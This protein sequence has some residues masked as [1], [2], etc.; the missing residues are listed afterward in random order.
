MKLG[1]PGITALIRKNAARL[2][3]DVLQPRDLHKRMNVNEQAL[4]WIE[5]SS[6]FCWII[7]L[8]KQSST[9]G[10]ELLCRVPDC[11]KTIESCAQLYSVLHVLQSWWFV[12]VFP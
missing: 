12:L 2:V 3:M 1:P 5:A 10:N 9:F 7:P 11:N 4:N 8:L 6:G